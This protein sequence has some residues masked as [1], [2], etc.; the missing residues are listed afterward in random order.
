MAT[1]MIATDGS[2]AAQ[3]A[4]EL[5][6]EIAQATGDD[7][8][9]V[10]VWDMIRGGIGAPF[11]Y[12]DQEYVDADRGVAEDVLTAAMARASELGVEAES[13]LL[14]GEPVSEICTTAR[15]RN[16][17]MIVIGA[18]GWSALKSMIH[19]S[20]VTGVLRYAPC[21]V[22]TGAP[23]TREIPEGAAVAGETSP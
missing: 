4:V 17:R 7:V 2:Q 8:L 19:G 15:H 3:S 16:V 6:L 22:L 14:F 21:P 1:I 9:F 13:C 12:I 20:V 11:G 23:G 18:H 10:S 5:G